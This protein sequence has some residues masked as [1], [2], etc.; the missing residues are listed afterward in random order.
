MGSISGG[1]RYDDLTSGFGLPGV[2]GVGISFGADRIY[3]VLEALG[4]FPDTRTF[5]TQLLFVA[6]DPAGL[7]Y[8]L[9]LLRQVRQAGCNAELYPEPAKLKKQLGYADK[10]QIPWV[11]IIGPDEMANGLLALKNLAT[12]QQQSTDL[13]GLLALLKN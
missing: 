9:P 4:G 6:M 3:D 11:A 13:P 1:G 2:P 7:R 8:A 5:G 10:K 12:G